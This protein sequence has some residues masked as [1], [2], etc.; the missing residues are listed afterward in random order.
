MKRLTHYTCILF[1]LCI[2]LCGC[3]KH[4]NEHNPNL[5]L[6]SINMG[7]SSGWF[8]AYRVFPQEWNNETKNLASPICM[9][10][11]DTLFI[12][13]NDQRYFNDTSIWTNEERSIEN[14]RYVFNQLQPRENYYYGRTS[15][16]IEYDFGLPP[17]LILS[18]LTDAVFYQVSDYPFAFLTE[19]DT[20]VLKH[21]HAAGGSIDY[22]DIEV[23]GYVITDTVLTLADLRIG[24][25]PASICKTFNL[26]CPNNIHHIALLSNEDFF[27]SWESTEDIEKRDAPSYKAFCGTFLTFSQDSLCRIETCNK[28]FDTSSNPR[29]LIE[30]VTGGT[31]W[32]QSNWCNYQPFQ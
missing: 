25:T 6:D 15:F 20:L 3:G 7:Y 13:T 17:S 26:T 2:F 12:F 8:K 22:Y 30:M 10:K 5:P 23:I 31:G 14:L 1:F 27:F 4:V 11:N 18:S 16:S 21:R 29:K 19:S 32:V 9:Q 24:Q 28:A